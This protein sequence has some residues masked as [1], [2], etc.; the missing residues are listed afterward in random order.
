MKH[1]AMTFV[2]PP[3][4]AKK[5]PACLRVTMP[6]H[7][8]RTLWLA[9]VACALPLLVGCGVVLHHYPESNLGWHSSNYSI[10][11]GVLRRH[12]TTP[13]S[14]TVRYSSVY[15]HDPYGGKF[16]LTPTARVVGYSSGNTVEIY[17]YPEPKAV[18]TAGTGTL[19]HVRS[20][21]LWLGKGRPNY[22][23]R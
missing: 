3:Q 6:R 23:T 12:D 8:R 22:L 2:K 1:N 11:F 10:I 7:A 13:V 19:Y 21:R 16:A 5:S 20:I 17:G 18:N 14:W 9:I 15:T 4:P